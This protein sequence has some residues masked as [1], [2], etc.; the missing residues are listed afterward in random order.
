M[1]GRTG[2]TAFG[3]MGGDLEKCRCLG[4][5]WHAKAALNAP[6][7]RVVGMMEALDI[8]KHDVERDLCI[9]S[10]SVVSIAAHC[11]YLVLARR[12]LV[13]GLVRGQRRGIVVCA[14]M[15]AHFLSRF[16]MWQVSCLHGSI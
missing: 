7:A 8:L 9:L 3:G 4:P 14:P 6:G 1:L 2:A 13:S 12:F 10:S 16:L 11:C 5:Q 15:Y